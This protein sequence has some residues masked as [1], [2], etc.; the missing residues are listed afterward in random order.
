MRHERAVEFGCGTG[1][2][3]TLPLRLSGYDVVGV[4]LDPASVD[5]GKRLLAEAGLDD[6]ALAVADLRDL[7]GELDAVIASEVLEHLSDP[8]LDRALASIRA[9]LAPG[10]RL[11]VTVPN[12]Y[13]WFELESLLWFGARI[14]WTLEVLR[15]VAALRW[16]KGQLT[17]GY[18]DAAHPS[19]VAHSPHAQRFTLRSIRARLEAAGFAVAEAE[20]SV[21]IAGPFSNLLLTGFERLMALNARLGRRL[22]PLAA[23]FYLVATASPQPGAER[24]AQASRTS[25]NEGTTLRGMS[26]RSRSSRRS[27]PQGV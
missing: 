20:G 25:R 26:S 6:G 4:D 5:Y 22:A 2:M 17:G 8:E 3:I 7:A 23:G 11:L 27:P 19:T 9:K 14:G 12:G 16:L 24:L 18:I 13:G 10:G 1:Y 21:L 15:I